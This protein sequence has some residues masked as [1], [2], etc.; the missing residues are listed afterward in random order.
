MKLFQK[1]ILCCLLVCIIQ[2][3]GTVDV[4]EKTESF[5]LHEWNGNIKP[6]F[7]FEIFDTTSLYNIFYV[8][9]HTDA[10]G[11]NNIWINVSTK[12]PTDSLNSQQ[13]NLQ[14]ADNKTG[15]LGNGMDDI[16]EHRIKIAGPSK[17]N[18]GKYLFT[19]EHIMR[20]DPLQHVLQAGIRVE[21]VNK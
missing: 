7:Q 16:F 11:F 12:S 4:Y 1:V 19:L 14:L 17:L 20:Q 9:R 5:K 3:C 6:S 18:K 21:K 2:S 10:Y 8:M 15:W 13:L